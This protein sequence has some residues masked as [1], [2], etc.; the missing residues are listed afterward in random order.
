MKRKRPLDNIIVERSIF[1]P[2]RTIGEK[3]KLLIIDPPLV[4]PSKDFHAT[5]NSS[6]VCYSDQQ[7]VSRDLSNFE[8]KDKALQTLND[9]KKRFDTDFPNLN[10]KNFM[11]E[12]MGIQIIEVKEPEP[13]YHI[14]YHS[15]MKQNTR[16][17][18]HGEE[19]QLTENFQDLVIVDDNTVPVY[20]RA[21]R[22][23]EPDLFTNFRT[24]NPGSSSGSRIYIVDRN[25]YF[26]SS[27]DSNI[28]DEEDRIDCHHFVKTAE[29]KVIPDGAAGSYFEDDVGCY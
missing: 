11:S 17:D 29:A 13:G 1:Q 12:A 24:A 19:V 26:L 14:Y 22:C 5:L 27:C 15:S 20:R 25:N 4:A 3:R 10:L 28:S 8:I 18:Y 21:Y 23:T 9:M 6:F 7:F 16:P 2:L